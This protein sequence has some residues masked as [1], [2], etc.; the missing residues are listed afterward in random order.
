MID[1]A[2]AARELAKR[3]AGDPN[4]AD[5]KHY[6]RVAGFTNQKPEHTKNGRQPYILAHE[7]AG[8]VAPESIRYLKF[9][10]KNIEEEKNKLEKA[11]RMKAIEAARDSREKT[12]QG[13]KNPPATEFQMQCQPWLLKFGDNA[14]LSRVDFASAKAMAQQGYSEKEIVNAILK[15]S[16][17]LL[18]R[19]EGHFEDY[20]IRTAGNA[21][22]DPDV[23]HA[24]HAEQQEREASYGREG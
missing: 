13:R 6:G 7:C 9:I 24:V 14:D 10:E 16:P 4:S 11:R 12:I 5:A 2:R 1:T 19:K 17:N 22:A 20:A 8:A 3:Y 21:A 23:V 18:T 15:A